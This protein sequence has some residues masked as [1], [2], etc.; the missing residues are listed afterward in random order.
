[1]ELIC[2]DKFQQLADISILIDNEDNY[3]SGIIQNQLK[4]INTNLHIFNNDN[5]NYIPDSIKYAKKIFVYTDIL[6]FFFKNILPFI[7]TKFILISHNSDLGV[8]S[9]Y[10]RFLNSDKIIKW[11]C[12]NAAFNHEKL[13][14]IP[15]GIANKQW[16][17]GNE[18][19]F[20]KNY[21]D[22]KDKN[23]AFGCF[24]ITTNSSF[25]TRI[26][27]IC[28]QSKIC[29]MYS[30]LD[31]QTFVKIM[32]KYK[33]TLCPIGNPV[34]GSAGDNHKV[35]ESLYVNSIPIVFENQKIIYDNIYKYL[36][37]IFAQDVN[38]LSDEIKL[39]EEFLKIKEKSKEKID[40]NY[41]KNIINNNL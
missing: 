9:E 6:N 28:S 23:K 14:P 26:W 15:I 16:E 22:F 13:I 5:K 35:Y 20:K 3:R 4:N 34:A 11:Y 29:D 38:I 40:F 39:E 12:Q 36:P 37:V 1:M 31:F 18:E 32:S 2:G 27:E 10:E 33:Y 30:K 19:I 25:R 24:N 7:Q 17:H 21:N 8:S 41:W